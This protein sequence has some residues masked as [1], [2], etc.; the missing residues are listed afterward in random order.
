V[1]ISLIAMR[2]SQGF[3]D[4]DLASSAVVAGLELQTTVGDFR[5]DSMKKHLR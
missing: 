5:T 1:V 2:A 3:T 4:C